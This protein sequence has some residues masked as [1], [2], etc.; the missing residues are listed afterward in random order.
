MTEV[1][2]SVPGYA[3]RFEV[4]DLGRVR[5]KAHTYTRFDPARGAVPTTLPGRVFALTQSPQGYLTVNTGSA[6][7][8][9]TTLVH[10]L[11][12]LAFLQKGEDATEVNHKNG[13]KADN[14]VCN[15]EWVTRSANVAH[16][17]SELVRKSPFT[18]RMVEA[19][20]PDGSTRRFNSMSAAARF[21]GVTVRAVACWLEGGGNRFGVTFRS[22][23]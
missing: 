16:S 18:A 19:L 22:T 6:G 1:W 9:R 8:G 15:L 23:T 3:D 2:K 5:T 17:H 11:V 10:R 7:T 21:Y 12:A 13:N 4:S 20:Y 14:R